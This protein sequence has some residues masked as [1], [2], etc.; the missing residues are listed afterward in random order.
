MRATPICRY[1]AL[2]LLLAGAFAVPANSN[3]EDTGLAVVAAQDDDDDGED[4]EDREGERREKERDKEEKRREKEQDRNNRGNDD[5]ANPVEPVA[6]YGVDVAC[7]AA[8]DA[9]STECTVAGVTPANG[10]KVSYI[11]IPES[12]VCTDV[13]GG[14][15]QYVDP[16]RQTD[17]TGYK[18][19]GG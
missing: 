18:S 7:T 14:E 2:L 19:R 5:S 15:H 1:L 9:A 6:D 12:A 17:V 11:V 3:V 4:E 13:I 8:G 16:D 10:K